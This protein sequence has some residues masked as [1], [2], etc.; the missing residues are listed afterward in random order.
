MKTWCKC[1]R[2][3]SKE[4]VR[5]SYELA[6]TIDFYY[7]CCSMLTIKHNLQLIGT[8][9]F[10]SKIDETFYDASADNRRSIALKMAARK[11]LPRSN[12]FFNRISIESLRIRK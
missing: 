6:I 11:L 1:K 8:S 4:H 3:L 2:F 5:L 7:L 9:N 12:G 10:R